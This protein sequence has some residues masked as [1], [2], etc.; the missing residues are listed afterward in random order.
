MFPKGEMPDSADQ[1]SSVLITL[2][3]SCS[4]TQFVFTL[5]LSV[6]TRRNQI[7]WWGREGSLLWVT[8]SFI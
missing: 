2:I 8:L 4:M 6:F 3:L 5:C 7:I 1:M